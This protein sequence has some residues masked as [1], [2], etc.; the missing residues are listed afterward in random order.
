MGAATGRG[1]HAVDQHD[2]VPFHRF[3]AQGQPGALL[4][5]EI[6]RD[7]RQ[8]APDALVGDGLRPNAVRLCGRRI[9]IDG[10][11][12]LAQVERDGGRSQ[13]VE[14]GGEQVLA[15]V[16][17][18]VIEPARPVDL[19]RDLAGLQRLGEDVKHGAPPLL[20]IGDLH[21]AQRAP[22]A[23]LAAPFGVERRAIEDR[24]G[25]SVQLADFQH[26]G[27]EG[28]EVGILEVEALGHEGGT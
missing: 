7:H 24:G 20:G 5:G 8:V 22:V 28:P 9:E 2:A 12:A 17:L 10:A 15:V 25:P 1:V 19:G 11:G 27:A 13:L 16:L 3:L 21:T 23:G 6:A 4:A 26:A 14:C 18:H